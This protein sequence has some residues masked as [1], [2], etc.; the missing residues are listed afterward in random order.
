MFSK[1]ASQA[2]NCEDEGELPQSSRKSSSGSIRGNSNEKDNNRE[3]KK[4]RK[5]L[6]AEIAKS[7]IKM[8]AEIDSYLSVSDSDHHEETKELTNK[9]KRKNKQNKKERKT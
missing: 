9:F 1:Q 6:D 4:Q 3:E 2:Q 5:E 7:D 8:R